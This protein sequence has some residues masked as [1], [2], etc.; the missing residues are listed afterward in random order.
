M[1]FYGMMIVLGLEITMHRCTLVHTQLQLPQLLVHSDQSLLLMV[2]IYL[3]QL[4]ILTEPLQLLIK[5]P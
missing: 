5:T 1:S 3:M 4:F 2:Q